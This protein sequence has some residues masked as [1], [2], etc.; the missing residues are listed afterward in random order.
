[1]NDHIERFYNGLKVGVEKVGNSFREGFNYV[2]YQLT[3]NEVYLT[4]WGLFIAP[5]RTTIDDKGKCR[6]TP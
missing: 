6:D 4:V 5:C 1:M 2:K 3:P